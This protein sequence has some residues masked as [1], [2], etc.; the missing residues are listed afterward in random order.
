MTRLY[1]EID[2]DGGCGGGLGGGERWTF[3]SRI[4]RDELAAS[5]TTTPNSNQSWSVETISEVLRSIPRF[6]FQ[7]T[8]SIGHQKSF[9]HRAPLKQRNLRDK[10]NKDRKG[11]LFLGPAAY[12]DPLKVKLGL[13]K[14]MEVYYWVEPHFG[15]THSEMTCR[16]MACVLAR[17][18]RL[19]AL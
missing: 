17:G 3:Y 1:G 12:R 15:F 4:E 5:A 6:F 16:E 10:S 14:A 2:G 8:R 9:R 18:N 7:S 13:D 19:K 11:L